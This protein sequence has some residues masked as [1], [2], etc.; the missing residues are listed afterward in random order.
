MSSCRLQVNNQQ[1]KAG[2]PHT[3]YI[4]RRRGK[5]E[6]A[7]QQTGSC[8]CKSSPGISTRKAPMTIKTRVGWST[9]IPSRG[10]HRVANLVLRQAQ[11]LGLDVW[12]CPIPKVG[13]YRTIGCYKPYCDQSHRVGLCC[14]I[15]R[16]TNLI[17]AVFN[18]R[19]QLRHHLFCRVCERPPGNPHEPACTCQGAGTAPLRVISKHMSYSQYY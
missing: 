9:F 8:D 16:V 11:I 10:Q 19:G 7:A 1:H 17:A 5:I 15:A 4:Q 18:P 2:L 14:S 12:E 6:R 3:H 13:D